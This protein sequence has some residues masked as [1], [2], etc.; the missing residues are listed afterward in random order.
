VNELAAAIGSLLFAWLGSVG[1]LGPG[2]G[3]AAAAATGAGLGLLVLASGGA[4]AVQRSEW[5]RLQ[6]RR[7]DQR[8]DGG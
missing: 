6:P 8:P 5:K 2:L 1:R 7:L 3:I 4:A